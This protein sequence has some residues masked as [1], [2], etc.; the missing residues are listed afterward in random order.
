MV[1]PRH[2]G[3]QAWRGPKGNTSPPSI[4]ADAGCRDVNM[5]ESLNRRSLRRVFAGGEATAAEADNLRLSFCVSVSGTNAGKWR[6]N[7]LSTPKC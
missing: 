4:F 6:R 1:R 3:G 5:R 2:P 7:W